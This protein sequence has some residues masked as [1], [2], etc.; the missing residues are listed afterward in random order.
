MPTSA[1]CSATAP[2][3][4]GGADGNLY[5]ISIEAQC[6]RAPI[7]LDVNLPPLRTYDV[8]NNVL[9]GP[10]VYAFG[11]YDEHRA[12][13]GRHHRRRPVRE[14]RLSWR[15]SRGRLR[16]DVQRRT[17]TTTGTIRSTAAT[18]G[19]TWVAQASTRRSTT[20]RPARR[21]TTRT[22]PSWRARSSTT[23]TRRTSSPCRKPK[24]R[25]CVGGACRP[26]SGGAVND[27]DGQPDVLQDQPGVPTRPAATRSHA[28]KLD[29]IGGRRGTTVAHAAH[30]PRAAA[31]GRRAIAAGLRPTDLYWSPTRTT[32]CAQSLVCRRPTGRRGCS[33]ARRRSR[34]SASIARA[35]QGDYVPLYVINNHFKQPHTDILR[36]P[37][38]R[39]HR[40]AD[41]G[42]AGRDPRRAVEVTGDLNVYRTRRA[43]AAVH[44]YG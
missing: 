31:A 20:Y 21:S 26:A 35:W 7:D 10:I 34:C 30:R 22:R 41:G 24:T 39:V 17:C 6:S 12:A 38:R 23:S 4:Y 16:R 1:A 2:A 33:R 32:S 40:H 43:L 8:V 42:T 28:V 27:A 13:A 3:D 18:S 29:R 14:Q 37:N 11:R 44:G 9:K 19:A 5:R 25:T 15:Q 36:R